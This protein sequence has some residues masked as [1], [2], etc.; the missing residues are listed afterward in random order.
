MIGEVILEVAIKFTLMQQFY[1]KLI[2]ISKCELFY[3]SL[4]NEL[5]IEIHQKYELILLYMM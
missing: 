3:K 1:H 5:K 4:A 2:I